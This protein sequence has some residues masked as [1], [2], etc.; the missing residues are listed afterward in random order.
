MFSMNSKMLLVDDS[1]PASR[2]AWRTWTTPGTRFWSAVCG[3]AR[4]QCP[5]EA[6]E[7]ERERDE[8]THN[9][10]LLARLDELGELAEGAD[11]P[12]ADGEALRVG[13]RLAQQLEEG[14]D[15]VL[16]VAARLARGNRDR[17]EEHEDGLEGDLAVG[18]RRRV[19]RVPQPR[20]EL[21]PDAL[22]EL[23]LGDGRHEARRGG[24]SLATASGGREDTSQLPLASVPSRGRE[25]DDA[26]G[27][28]EEEL[29]EAALE[30]VADLLGLC[31]PLLVLLGG[32]A[33][34]E[35]DERELAD[36]WR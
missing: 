36:L 17:V 2:V 6:A 26:L 19:G 8:A 10:L 33:L 29:E 28:G 11:R 25:H 4:S 21:G 32:D 3:C 9:L 20:E 23:E 34:A 14:R 13:E 18:G 5:S 7:R 1:S 24:A 15:L 16:G 30:R 27:L 22:L 35:L 12:H 31:E